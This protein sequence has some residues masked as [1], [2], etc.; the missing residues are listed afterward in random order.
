MNYWTTSTA[1]T[2][3]Y[4]TLKNIISYYDEIKNIE[5]CPIKKKEHLPEEL[6]NIEDW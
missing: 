1:S 2:A 4:Y 5:K 3:S 6:W